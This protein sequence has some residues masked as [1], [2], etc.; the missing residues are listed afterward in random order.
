MPNVP[1]VPK[2]L[3]AE[4]S[5]LGA[6]ILDSAALYD[7]LD[8]VQPGDFW[9]VRH[10]WVYEA[11][12]SLHRRGE[13]IDYVT[14]VAELGKAGR[15][16]EVGG[17]AFVTGLLTRTPFS[18]YAGTYGRIVRAASVRRRLITAAGDIAKL[19]YDG[20]KDLETVVGEAQAALAGATGEQKQSDLSAAAQIVSRVFDDVE[21]RRAQGTSGIPTGFVDLDRDM[22]GLQ[23]SDLTII[24][25]R[26]GMGKTAWLLTVAR[27]AARK[28]KK[29]LVVSLEMSQGQNIQRLIAMESKVATEKQRRGALTDDEFSAFTHGV[30]AVLRLPLWVLDA[31][32]M[33]PDTLRARV[34]RLHAEHKLDLIIVDYLQLMTSGGRKDGNRVQEVSDISRGLKQLARELDV[35]VIAAAQLSRAVEARADKRP[36]L[37]DLRE[38]GSIEQDA[39]VVLMLYRDD[40]YNPN[41][42]RKRQAD[43]IIAKHRNGPTGTVSLYFDR[44]L[45]QF[46]D[47]KRVE[48]TSRT[49]RGGE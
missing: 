45:T 24:A 4:A 49:H 41:S 16:E 9:L 34:K 46:H 25:G 26:P 48:M 7:V 5:L 33:T 35:P 17:A 12:L 40:Y 23:P 39:D 36:M 11:M 38:S 28:G 3:D 30:E 21:R 2:S 27:N 42:D 44:A 20:D 10:Q 32:G 18:G 47:L 15:L 31:P 13:A 1:E 14:V 8:V 37:S 29:V 43:V 19:A 22:G 6:I